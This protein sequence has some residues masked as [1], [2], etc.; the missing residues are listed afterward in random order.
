MRFLAS[1][2]FC[3]LKCVQAAILKTQLPFSMQ[4]HFDVY[5]FFFP[6]AAAAIAPGS[7]QPFSFIARFEVVIIF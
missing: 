4:A 2:S 1:L 5:N 3:L 7:R 6:S